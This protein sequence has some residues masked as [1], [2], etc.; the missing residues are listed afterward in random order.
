M[1]LFGIFHLYGLIIGVAVVA[2]LLTISAQVKFYHLN[3]KLVDSL[4][5]PMLLGAVI[6]ARVYHLVTDW[7]LYTH[8][9]FIDLIAI[10]NGGVGFL[11]GVIGGVVGLVLYTWYV[12]HKKR[13]Y[14]PF[15]STLDL[16]SFGI[17]MAQ[18]IGRFG[19][20]VNQELYGLP[21]TLPWGI[22]IHGKKY[23]PLFM[24][25][26]LCTFSLFLLLMFLSRK[27]KLFF[28]KGQFAGVYLFSYGL[29]RFWLEF[30]R[31]ETSRLPGNL[32]ILSTAQYVSFGLMVV[33]VVLFWGRRHAPTIQWDFSM[34]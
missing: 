13:K 2:A 10:W 16:F 28:G 30:L 5:W 24:Y 14:M 26:S 17:P 9:S 34:R 20:L 6:G 22:V 3:Q 4:F 18:S 29:I 32:G 33:G 7:Q 21:T 31:I 25:E 15:F 27:Q 23:H 11:G 8:A 12:Q 1:T 19:N